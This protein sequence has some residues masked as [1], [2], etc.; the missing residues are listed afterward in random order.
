MKD[1][2]DWQIQERQVN[3]EPY[4]LLIQVAAFGVALGC[5]SGPVAQ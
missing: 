5:H 3:R 4:R 2:N 1:S